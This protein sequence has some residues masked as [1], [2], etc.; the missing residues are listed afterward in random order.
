VIN[1]GLA[2]LNMQ[3]SPLTA[4]DLEH[5]RVSLHGPAEAGCA[6][7]WRI[8]ALGFSLS[9]MVALHYAA[10]CDGQATEILG[11]GKAIRHYSR[12]LIV[13]EALDGLEWFRSHSAKG[14]RRSNQIG[15]GNGKKFETP[16]GYTAK[17]CA[18]R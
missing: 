13:A 14:A 12:R 6:H 8:R 4:L 18:V 5:E 7:R 1:D 2:K 16:R 15:F 17:G 10:V 3:M 11:S 9:D